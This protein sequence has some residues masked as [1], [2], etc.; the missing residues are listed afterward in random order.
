MKSNRIDPLVV[1][2]GED[3]PLTDY[4]FANDGASV[5]E[6]KVDGI[7]NEAATIPG[8]Q[9]PIAGQ[10]FKNKARKIASVKAITHAKMSSTLWRD[11]ATRL[12]LRRSRC[13]RSK[14]QKAFNV[15]DT[16][17]GRKYMQATLSD[18]EDDEETDQ[19]Q[20]VITY[21]DGTPKPQTSFMKQPT[22]DSHSKALLHYFAKVKLEMYFRK[23]A[24]LYIF[25]TIFISR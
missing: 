22:V 10:R 21:E 14:Q 25:F 3:V 19:D 18:I 15:I 23:C 13:K 1:G 16:I 5:S 8:R 4:Y 7:V 11:K 2:V 20:G 17:N 6:K 12:V 9:T 24:I